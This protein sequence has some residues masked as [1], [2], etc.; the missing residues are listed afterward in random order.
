MLQESQEPK[1]AEVKQNLPQQEAVSSSQ[2][3]D[4]EITEL[5]SSN[6][7]KSRSNSHSSSTTS[8]VLFVNT[9]TLPSK[10]VVNHHNKKK[11]T[12]DANYLT[13]YGCRLCSKICSTHAGIVNHLKA[14]AKL[15]ARHDNILNKHCKV[16][17]CKTD[18]KPNWT[19]SSETVVYDKDIIYGNV[20]S[21]KLRYNS[22][23][24]NYNKYTDFFVFYVSK[25][26]SYK[27]HYSDKS[28]MQSQ[29]LS[30]CD[31]SDDDDFITKRP[32][33]K[34]RRLVSDS[35]KETVVLEGDNEK[36]SV[37]SDNE[38]ESKRTKPN[39]VSNEEKVIDYINI[40][41]SS[42]TE[43]CTSTHN[44]V[45]S[46]D[47]KNTTTELPRILD[48][49]TLQ[50]IIIKCSKKFIQKKKLGSR[51]PNL[52]FN[53]DCLLKTKMLSM[54]IKVLHPHNAINCTGLLRYMEYK[55]LNI[56]W[57]P[58]TKAGYGRIMPKLKAKDNSSNDNLRWK[59]V[60]GDAVSKP[61]KIN[62]SPYS[63][64]SDT[65]LKPTTLLK[66]NENVTEL[67]CSNVVPVSEP[68]IYSEVS[69]MECDNSKE[70]YSLNKE[71][72]QLAE[73][74][75]QNK[76]L[77]LEI[78]CKPPSKEDDHS[79][80][81]KPIPKP[82]GSAML[83]SLLASGDSDMKLLNASPVAN[84][85]QLP[86]KANLSEVKHSNIKPIID[87]VVTSPQQIEPTCQGEEKD[88]GGS[89]ESLCMPIITS[90]TSLANDKTNQDEKETNETNNTEN[91][92]LKQNASEGLEKSVPRIKVKPAS[93]L[94][95]EKAFNRLGSQSQQP[96][97]P[98]TWNTTQS[99]TFEP[100]N[101]ANDAKK[102][103]GNPQMVSKE[104]NSFY[105][106]TPME[107]PREC[108]ILDTVEFPNT[109]TDSPF[110]YFQN[111]LFIHNIILLDST[112]KFS[113][114]FYRLI[115][116]RLVLNEDSMN[117]SVVLCLALQ[118]AENEFC[119]EVKGQFQETINLQQLSA[120]WQWEII[121]VF[122]GNIEPNLLKN[123]Q[124][125]GQSAYEYT[126]SFLC[127]LKS[128]NF[129]KTVT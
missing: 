100:Q 14:H 26:S 75:K 6:R 123:A 84:P 41:D 72:E 38:S 34:R 29:S 53:L 48:K 25:E 67:P 59:D 62:V 50:N 65:V 55:K 109:K 99:V 70:Y 31:L 126:K 43:S 101:N 69:R 51:L 71:L 64:Q 52:D 68:S 13:R 58:T 10:N 79:K 40:D 96:V 83:Y 42:D 73:S 97:V 125:L 93:E 77:K 12:W 36:T 124:K 74:S 57:T 19:N 39:N 127:L 120:N 30:N 76:S 56:R 91:S 24:N 115:K 27:A 105:N 80:E 98:S 95:T 87:S 60:P 9:T 92:V 89:T 117:Q 110:K 47:S 85:K 129:F 1:D 4:N 122:K 44:D 23:K 20:E 37:S 94:M 118:C 66:C 102:H 22:N 81:N 113:R 18:G 8:D 17:L 78:V 88:D 107:K 16:S 61:L 2:Q 108:V 32:S 111:L 7:V 28:V 106:P 86:K 49:E 35:S 5:T 3:N 82:G 11:P 46:E 116:F 63:S 121:K 21:L 33:K 54:G 114:N 128:I 45:H 112:D 119:L 103:E 104:I 15:R 90:T